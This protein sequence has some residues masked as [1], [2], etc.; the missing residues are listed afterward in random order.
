MAV[1]AAW[2]AYEAVAIAH[3]ALEEQAFGAYVCE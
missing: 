1:I 3:A 2:S